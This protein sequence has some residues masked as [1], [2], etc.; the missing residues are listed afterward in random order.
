MATFVILPK[1]GS[2]SKQSI[3]LELKNQRITLLV[4]LSKIKLFCCIY[5]F[6]IT[7]AHKRGE[8]NPIILLSSTR[9][10]LQVTEC[11]CLCWFVTF[12]TNQ[13]ASYLVV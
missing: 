8:V 6:Q 12:T 5:T 2:P 10:Q 9:L 11:I 7:V 1:A 3:T 4:V 13:P